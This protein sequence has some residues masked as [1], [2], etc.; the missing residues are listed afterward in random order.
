MT[1]AGITAEV[2]MVLGVARLGEAD[3]RG[4]CS[5]HGLGRAGAF[6]LE[7]TQEA[8][9]QSRQQAKYLENPKL[10]APCLRSM[11]SSTR[12]LSRRG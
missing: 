2:K 6:V 1:T 5:S 7:I 12:T 11:G 9:S 8:D 4:W 10:K 3:L